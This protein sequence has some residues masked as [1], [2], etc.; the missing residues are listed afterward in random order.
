MVLDDLQGPT[1]PY[2]AALAFVFTAL[3]LVWTDLQGRKDW[4]DLDTAQ[5]WLAIL[6]P[7]V[8]TAGGV[9]LIPNPARAR[10]ARGEAGRAGVHPVVIILVMALAIAIV[11]AVIWG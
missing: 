5:E 11:V 7:A 4:G 9:F 1:K 3:A 8:L 2:K 6:V 10:R